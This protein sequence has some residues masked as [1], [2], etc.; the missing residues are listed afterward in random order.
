MGGNSIQNMAELSPINCFQIC[1]G[2]EILY[3]MSGS[4]A[5]TNV[6]TNEWCSNGT[7]CVL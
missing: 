2:N 5:R 3:V 6:L 1:N 7:Y 4:Y